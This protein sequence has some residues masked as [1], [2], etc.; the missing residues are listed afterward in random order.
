MFAKLAANPR[1]VP[2]AIGLDEDQGVCSSVCKVPERI[3]T[4][5]ESKR[6]ESDNTFSAMDS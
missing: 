1:T 6:L 5:T 3:N 4:A 2:E